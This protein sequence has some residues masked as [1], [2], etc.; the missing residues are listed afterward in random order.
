M[1]IL[2]SNPPWSKNGYC[3]VRAG[4]RWPHI[5][6]KT[7][8]GYLPFPFYLAYTASLIKSENF[9]FR[10]WDALSEGVSKEEFVR[11]VLRK[12]YKLII[13]ET[14]TAS[15]NN[16]LE[17]LKRIKKKGSIIAVAGPDICIRNPRFLVENEFVDCV[18]IGEYEYTVLEIVKCIQNGSPLDDI[19]GLIYRDGRGD[20]K[21]NPLR[22]LISNLDELPWPHREGLPMM[23]YLDAPGDMPLPS[24]Q[25]IASRGCPF[26]CIFCAWPQLMYGGNSYRTRSIIDVLDEM[27]FVVRE[28]KFKSVYFD[29]DTFN[30]GK[31]R[32]LK[33]AK[34]LTKRNRDNRINVPW[35]IMARADLMDED[36]LYRFQSCGL[37]AIKYG[38]ESSDKKLLE[39]ANKGTDLERVKAMVSLTKKLGIKTHLTFTFGLPGENWFTILNTLNFVVRQDPDSVQFSIATPFPGTYFYEFVKKKNFLVSN[40]PSDYDG[41]QKS[42]IRTEYLNAVDLEH[43]RGLAYRIWNCHLRFRK[44]Y[45]I[46]SALIRR[47]RRKPSYSYLRF[48]VTSVKEN[49]LNSTIIK[50]LKFFSPSR[51]K[52]HYFEILGIRS[53]SLAYKGPNFIHIDL[54]NNCN[55]NCIGCWCNSPLL[56]EKKIEIEEKNKFL[57]YALLV[58]LIEETRRMGTKRV[59]FGGGGEPLMHPDFLRLVRLTKE[60]GLECY[61]STNF[62]LVDMNLLDELIKVKPQELAVSIWA[63]TGETYCL[64]HP[65]KDMQDFKNIKSNLSYLNNR[66]KLYPK[67]K[68]CNVITRLNYF[69]ME[70]MVEFALKTKSDIVEFTV[71]DVIPAKTESLLLG[72]KERNSVL[73]SCEAIRKKFLK[74]RAKMKISNLDL[75]ERRISNPDSAR[76]IYDS[77]IIGKIPCYTGWTFSRISANGN[78]NFCLKSHRFPV[79][80]IYRERFSDIW[81]SELQLKLRKSALADRTDNFFKMTGNAENAYPGCERVCDD[82]VRNM[83]T[84]NKILS[85]TLVERLILSILEKAYGR[86]LE[87]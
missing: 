86:K 75:F 60:K 26:R 4:S 85:L 43:A 59:A 33:F 74:R 3:G 24:V 28:L 21:T 62:T 52:G 79:G 80:N 84:H 61:I 1:E 49:S 9:K 40:E 87:K 11:E 44:L 2:L 64:V 29:D 46:L 54:T 39:N 55:N 42:V 19:L 73:K 69:E 5:K 67:V 76:G 31:D 83:Y 32:M 25:L 15:L 20:I 45:N 23:K 57:P 7:E 63:A 78:V 36:I 16:D 81:N 77:D 47:P 17:I 6:D 30:I 48:L 8:G 37:H 14:S 71:I 18:I 82:L 12:D 70:E 56:G 10:L 58:N 35:A 50:L 41:N 34:E 13:I 22:P 27:E 53:G 66:K 51:L 38:V 68:I 72:E 65:N